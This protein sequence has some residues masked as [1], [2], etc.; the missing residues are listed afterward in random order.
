MSLLKF[1][2]SNDYDI[3]PEAPVTRTAAEKI[4][5]LTLKL[6][7]E[8]FSVQCLIW[9][10]WDSMSKLFLFDCFVFVLSVFVIDLLKGHL[11]LYW[12]LLC[13]FYVK[14][15]YLAWLCLP[16]A[17]WFSCKLLFRVSSFLSG[18]LIMPHK[19]IKASGR[20]CWLMGFENKW[21]KF[22]WKD[23]VPSAR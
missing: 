23:G 2:C 17:C 19:N 21:G 16:A 14:M 3:F 11:C 22:F 12:I 15:Y 9:F 7:E 20:D 6:N 13:W 5:L 8:T 10:E 4:S 1:F 18:R